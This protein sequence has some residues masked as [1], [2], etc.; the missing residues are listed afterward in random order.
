M[1][2]RPKMPANAAAHAAHDSAMA[3]IVIGSRR[4]E[5]DRV[6][7][8][9]F[10]AA[11]VLGTSEREVRNMLRRGALADVSSARTRLIDPNELAG[12]IEGRPIELHT[13][14]ELLEGR[15]TARETPWF[16]CRSMSD[17]PDRDDRSDAQDRR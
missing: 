6:A 5:T 17:V 3:T 2:A 12:L 9:P 15:V 16:L 7:I 13:L 4:V 14:A 1:Q 10:E 11:F 8:T